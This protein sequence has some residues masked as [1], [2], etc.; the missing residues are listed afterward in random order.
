MLAQLIALLKNFSH[1]VH[2]LYSYAGTVDS[3]AEEFLTNMYSYAGK[4]D[5]SAQEFLTYSWA[6]TVDSAA[7][8]FS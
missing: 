3:L 1:A 2:I 4:V 6:G 8:D 7:E 5:S